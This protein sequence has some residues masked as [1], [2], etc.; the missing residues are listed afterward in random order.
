L[1]LPS[2][3]VYFFFLAAFLAAFF[4]GFFFA[5]AM[6]HLTLD[7]SRSLRPL[8]NV[9]CWRALEKRG[10]RWKTT[11]GILAAHRS[12]ARVSSG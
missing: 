7:C 3:T 4:A 2:R 12:D 1:K 6:I 5:V 9:G 10:R 8:C 11:H